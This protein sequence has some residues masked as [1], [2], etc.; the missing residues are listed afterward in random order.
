MILEGAVRNYTTPLCITSYHFCSQPWS[1]QPSW[2]VPVECLC[3]G[4]LV[5]SAL[6]CSHDVILMQYASGT[7]LRRF[8]VWFGIC[9]ATCHWC[10]PKCLYR[11]SASC[12]MQYAFSMVACTV[13]RAT[14]HYWFPKW[15]YRFGASR[16]TPPAS[17]SPHMPEGHWGSRA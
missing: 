13:C 8:A 5:C 6:L 14:C 15:L 12:Q 16:W 7:A 3:N 9:I 2:A 10:F 11:L 4:L 17:G 1:E